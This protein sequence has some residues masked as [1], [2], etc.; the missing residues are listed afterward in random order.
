MTNDKEQASRQITDGNYYPTQKS[1]ISHPKDNSRRRFLIG[2]TLG[3]A[4][5]LSGSVRIVLT[6]LPDLLPPDELSATYAA[7]E[8][9]SEQLLPDGWTAI[10]PGIAEVERDFAD[11]SYPVPVALA[12]RLADLT[13]LPVSMLAEAAGYSRQTAANA[14]RNAMLDYR[15]QL[16]G[17]NI[18]SEW[19][20]TSG[21]TEIPGLSVRRVP[22]SVLRGGQSVLYYHDIPLHFPGQSGI[23]TPDTGQSRILPGGFLVIPVSLLSANGDT[24][25][26]PGLAIFNPFARDIVSVIP[27]PDTVMEPAAHL[28][29][30]CISFDMGESPV[31]TDLRVS[32]TS[33]P[34]SDLTVFTSAPDGSLSYAWTAPV[35]LDP[36]AINRHITDA[37]EKITSVRPWTLGTTVVSFYR[38]A[39]FSGAIG[40]EVTTAGGATRQR[41]YLIRS[42]DPSVPG[43]GFESVGFDRPVPVSDRTADQILIG[44]TERIVLVGDVIKGR[45]TGISQ[46]ELKVG[47]DLSVTP[48]PFTP[49]SIPI[50][51]KQAEI[52]TMVSFKRMDTTP[53]SANEKMQ[54]T[55]S[56]RN[57][58]TYGTVLTER[59]VQDTPLLETVPLGNEA[60]RRYGRPISGAL[61][62]DV[63]GR[64]VEGIDRRIPISRNTRL[65]YIPDARTQLEPGF[66]DYFLSQEGELIRQ[67]FTLKYDAAAGTAITEFTADLKRAVGYDEL[68]AVMRKFGFW[69]LPPA[70]DPA[71]PDTGV[72][73]PDAPSRSALSLSLQVTRMAAMMAGTEHRPEIVLAGT[74]RGADGLVGFLSLTASGMMPDLAGRVNILGAVTA[75]RTIPSGEFLHM[76]APV[77]SGT[78]D[79]TRQRILAGIQDPL[80]PAYASYSAGKLPFPVV[81]VFDPFFM[82]QAFTALDLSPL[83]GQFVGPRMLGLRDQ[84]KI[85]SLIR[86]LSDTSGN[87]AQTVLKTRIDSIPDNRLM[88]IL[89]ARN[90]TRTQQSF[91]PGILSAILLPP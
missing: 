2:G 41:V 61:E 30:G 10:D 39:F 33:E 7:A 50:P 13:P 87:P 57:N 73:A 5:A 74:L 72:P 51:S 83:A 15:A 78:D 90:I 32:D 19:I 60:S 66:V 3:A 16:P 45:L 77:L 91:P 89:N 8:Q 53:L 46:I 12:N 63:S 56:G 27:L 11:E 85:D 28:I 65:L 42:N 26:R 9:R 80:P 82:P 64:I 49:V 86:A 75:G 55:F 38:S 59:Y 43:T 58:R 35:I 71:N 68:F 44:Q 31:I 88:D 29:S 6:P 23:S 36:D 34:D 14:I 48:L 37:R 69:C 25:N 18:V 22:E 17:K 21:G 24:P 1:E 47:A 76:L 40:C 20:G 52:R 79:R 84:R 54:L 67:W 70:F 81:D 62:P 4:G